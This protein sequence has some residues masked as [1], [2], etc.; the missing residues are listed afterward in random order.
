MTAGFLQPFSPAGRASVVPPPPWHYS[1]ELLVVEYPLADPDAAS[2]FLF[3]GVS[4]ESSTAAACFAAWVSSSDAW[5]EQERRDPLRCQYHEAFIL[6]PVSYGPPREAPRTWARCV[7]MWV[8]ADF[9]LARGWI[10]GYPKKMGQ[11]AVSRP[12]ALGIGG[13][14]L[15]PGEVFAGVAVAGGHRL[16]SAT[17]TLEGAGVDAP[18]IA[19]RPFLLS[20]YLP[21]LDPDVPS[22]VE[23]VRGV[24]RDVAVGDVWSG[25]AE[26]VIGGSPAEELDAFLPAGSGRGF[27]YSS[28][29][30]VDAAQVLEVREADG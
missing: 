18:A 26:V 16:V 11:V 10:Q 2:A 6:L 29:F 30:T 19:T 1:G 15:A 25:P 24:T 20:R 28:A 14:R 27:F 5:R 4:L 9:S 3:P 8:D 22:R 12:A 23:I 17:V 13:P 21:S 7:A